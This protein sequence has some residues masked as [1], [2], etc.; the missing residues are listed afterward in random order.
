MWQAWSKYTSINEHQMIIELV[1]R[2]T[3]GQNS[4]SRRIIIHTGATRIYNLPEH[5]TQSINLEID[6]SHRIKGTTLLR[7]HDGFTRKSVSPGIPI[8]IRP[9]EIC[10]RGAP[11]IYLPRG[12]ERVCVCADGFDI[13]WFTFLGILRREAARALIGSLG[14]NLTLRRESHMK[15][16]FSLR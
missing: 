4:F 6:K 10:M 12:D 7:H 1:T 8:T 5:K 14:C 2:I 3:L 16:V 15:F 13:V 9:D 11:I